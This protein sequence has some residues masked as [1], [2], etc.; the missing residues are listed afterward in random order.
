MQAHYLHLFHVIHT[1]GHIKLPYPSPRDH[2]TILMTSLIEILNTEIP[3]LLGVYNHSHE[4]YMA[5]LTDILIVMST[6][7]YDN[8]QQEGIISYVIIKLFN[9]P[10]ILSGQFQQCSGP[11]LNHFSFLEPFLV[12]KTFY[13]G[14]PFLDSLSLLL[15]H[16][17][18]YLIWL[19]STTRCQFNPLVI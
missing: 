15:E 18:A 14:N 9:I 5:S 1:H 4:T 8:N 7:P 6:F 3:S 11:S 10:Y 16:T 13:Q 2:T 19:P 12:N 17:K